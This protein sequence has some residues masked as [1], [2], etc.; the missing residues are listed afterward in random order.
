MPMTFRLVYLFRCVSGW[1]R[2]SCSI[3]LASDLFI[4]VGLHGNLRASPAR[5]HN[6][7]STVLYQA[8]ARA[9]PKI[10]IEFD[11]FGEFVS[12]GGVA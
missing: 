10:E 7:Q 5:I 12:A 6:L 4:G 2:V 11:I 8:V 1:R 9:W 3:G